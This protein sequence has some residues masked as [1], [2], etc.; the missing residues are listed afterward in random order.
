[1]QYVL[2]MYGEEAHGETPTQ[3]TPERAAQWDA[4]WQAQGDDS[5]LSGWGALTP[6]PTATTL[7]VGREGAPLV[8]DGPFAET[9][10]QLGGFII[11]ECAELDAALAFAAQVPCAPRGSIEVRAIAE[12]G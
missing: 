1:M 12:S 9:K 10:E 3:M 6:T 8:T 4:F 5:P 2:L 11:I 7:R